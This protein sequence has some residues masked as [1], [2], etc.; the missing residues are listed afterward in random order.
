MVDV[1]I[2]LQLFAL[3]LPHLRIGFGNRGVLGQVPV[4]DK[5]AAV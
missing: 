4:D 3:E 2:S 5:L 1:C